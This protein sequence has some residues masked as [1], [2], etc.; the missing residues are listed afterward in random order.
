M[1]ENLHPGLIAIMILIVSVFVLCAI[2]CPK[3]K[4]F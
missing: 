3:E 2:F 1:L 4:K